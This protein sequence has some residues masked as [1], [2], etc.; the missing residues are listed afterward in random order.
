MVSTHD[1][2]CECSMFKHC[3]HLSMFQQYYAQRL[4][5]FDILISTCELKLKEIVVLTMVLHLLPTIN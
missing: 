1:Q 4:A 3:E 5:E 2:T